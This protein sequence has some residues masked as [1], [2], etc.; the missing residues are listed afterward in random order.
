LLRNTFLNMLFD[1]MDER[2]DCASDAM[3]G[4]GAVYV[5]WEED[6]VVDEDIVV[7]GLLRLVFAR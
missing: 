3:Y 1:D 7:V 6:L 5:A 2:T 4:G